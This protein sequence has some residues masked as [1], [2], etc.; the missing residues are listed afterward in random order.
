MATCESFELAL[1]R[2]GGNHCAVVTGYNGLQAERVGG[3]AP[4][5]GQIRYFQCAGI[6]SLPEVLFEGPLQRKKKFLS[7][8]ES[9][10]ENSCFASFQCFKAAVAL[11]SRQPL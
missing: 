7:C 3:H 9:R 2:R 6:R 8:G 1:E 10:S 11:K 5:C 4:M